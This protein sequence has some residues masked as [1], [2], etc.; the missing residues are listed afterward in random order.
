MREAGDDQHAKHNQAEERVQMTNVV[1]K[2]SISSEQAQNMV[3]K[4]VAKGE[5]L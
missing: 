4:A 2:H 1:K 5:M 3:D